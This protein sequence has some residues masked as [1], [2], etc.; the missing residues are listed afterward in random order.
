MCS[1]ERVW[2]IFIMWDSDCEEGKN[3]KKKKKRG[4][5]K[6]LILK[7][8]KLKLLE[9]PD[10]LSVFQSIFSFSD[11]K[12]MATNTKRHNSFH[13]QWV[14]YRL[15]PLLDAKQI[16]KLTPLRMLLSAELP[17]DKVQTPTR[18]F[19]K[20]EKRQRQ[21]LPLTFVQPGSVHLIVR[22]CRRWKLHFLHAGVV[23][24]VL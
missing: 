14:I 13:N 6:C 24:S 18:V 2:S 23:T 5:S 10:C 7:Y 20:E 9:L 8:H 16:H 22:V 19:V 21:S 4:N 1:L 12:R 11:Y 15:V 3:K 17:R